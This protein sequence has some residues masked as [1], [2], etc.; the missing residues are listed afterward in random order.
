MPQEYVTKTR[1]RVN[2]EAV[3]LSFNNQDNDKPLVAQSPEIDAETIREEL[4]QKA[5]ATPLALLNDVCADLTKVTSDQARY[6]AQ[7]G[8]DFIDTKIKT[9]IEIPVS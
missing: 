5:I 7:S 8:R 2:G 6:L 9:T 3:N 1:E 4:R